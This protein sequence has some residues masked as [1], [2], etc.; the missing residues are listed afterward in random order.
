MLEANLKS[1]ETGRPRVFPNTAIRSTRRGFTLIELLV[2]IAIIAVLAA[3]LLPALAAAKARAQETACLSNLR[4]W[5]VGL[6]TYASDAADSIPRDGTDASGSYSSYTGNTSTS[7][8]GWAGSPNDPNAWFN[9]LPPAMGTATLQAYYLQLG[10]NYQKKYP[11]S[12]NGVGP[13][14]MCPSIQTVPADNGLFLAGGQFGFFS[15]DMNLDLKLW[16]SIDN[17]VIGNSWPWPSMP[18]LTSIHNPDVV[19]MMTEFCFSPTLENFTGSSQ[20]QMGTFPA[21]RWT[22]FVKRHNNGGNLAFLDGHSQYFKYDY[23]FNTAAP[24]GRLEVF[25]ADIWWNPNRNAKTGP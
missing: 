3:I 19:V 4:Q 14:W 5:G 25:N 11:F 7:N 6:Q 20:P 22:Y 13:V 16:S 15:Y 8:P 24:S 2:V 18:K 10:N 9:V 17:G 12:G 23:V 1:S 21:C